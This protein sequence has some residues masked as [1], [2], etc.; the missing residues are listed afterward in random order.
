VRL[1]EGY[2]TTPCRLCSG[3]GKQPGEPQPDSF[4]NY[5]P[6]DDC[7]GE[8]RRVIPYSFCLDPAACAGLTSCPRK[9][10]CSE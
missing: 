3:T 10:S 7:D 4:G 5:T 6:C 9:L 1:L 8:G 2:P